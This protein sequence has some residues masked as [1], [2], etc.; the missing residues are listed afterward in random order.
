M[1]GSHHVVDFNQ[2]KETIID[3]IFKILPLKAKNC[4]KLNVEDD[5]SRKCN[6]HNT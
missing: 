6:M 5:F 1:F 2:T 3:F 4:Q